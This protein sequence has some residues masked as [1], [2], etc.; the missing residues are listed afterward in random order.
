MPRSRR[1]L[2]DV[3]LHWSPMSPSRSR[4][5]GWDLL[6]C[7]LAAAMILSGCAGTGGSANPVARSL[8][9]FNYLNGTELRDA[10]ATG[11]DR[12][13][14]IYNARW[15]EQVRTYDIVRDHRGRGDGILAA[16]V[17]FPEGLTQ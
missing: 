15:G 11:P 3:T 9:W 13:R 17:L 1:C 7:G 12:Y 14:F 2:P 16:R 5:S 10:C 6:C 8:G 4:S